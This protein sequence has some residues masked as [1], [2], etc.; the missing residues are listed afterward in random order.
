[1]RPPVDDIPAPPFPAGAAWVNVA[2]LRMDQQ[3]GRPVLVEFWDFCR[4]NSLRTLP[5]VKAWHERYADAG[6]RVVT[7]HCPGFPPAEDEAAARAAVARLQISHPVCLDLGF[8]LWRSYDNEG[9][10]AR[11]LWD[12]QGHLA[13]YHYGEGGYV[14]TE[15]AIQEL[16]GVQREVVGPLHPEDDPQ[17]QIVAQTPDQAGA[18]SGPYAAGGVWAVLAGAGEVAVNGERREVSWP[19]AH[20]LL[21]HP[22]HVEGVLDLDVGTGVT[23]YATCFTPGLAPPEA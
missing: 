2:P 3:R 15:H 4:P 11:Y 18:Y 16:V 23:C 19:G 5:Y 1:M 17:A 21:D 12:A 13:E 20:Q 10:P 8:E 9:W 6:L 14:E 7:V 22:Y